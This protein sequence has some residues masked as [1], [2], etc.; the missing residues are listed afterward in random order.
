[1]TAPPAFL[2]APS[3]LQDDRPVG[4]TPDG[5]ASPQ[6]VAAQRQ[7]RV[8]QIIG[9]ALLG[10]TISG[11]A[12]LASGHWA[13]AGVLTA[14]SLLMVLAGLL[15]RAKSIGPG[16]AVLLGSLTVMVS[17]FSWMNHGLRDHS[18]LV[19]PAILIFAGVFGSW[20]LLFGLLA[21]M[22]T[23]VSALALADIQGWHR[24][25]VPAFS[26][27]SPVNILVILGVTAASVWMMTADLRRALALLR[28]ENAR[29]ERS[30]EQLEHM[31]RHDAL[32][33]LP[34]RLVA[35]DRFESARRRANRSSQNVALL[36]LDLDQFKT[37]NDSLGHVAGDELLVQAGQRLT[38]LVRRADTVCRLGG[39]EFL[40][41]LPDLGD[42]QAAAALATKV[43]QVLAEP[44]TVCG[45]EVSTTASI[46]V[47]LHPQDGH[48]FDEVLKNVDIAMYKAKE[49]GGNAVRF[50]N[51]E[52]NAGVLEHT[53]LLAGMRAGLARGEFQLHFQ[54][55]HAL[56]SGRVIG[57]E[58]LLRWTHPERGPISPVRFIPVAEKSGFIVELGA[59]VVREACRQV[60]RWEPQLPAGFRVS[61]NLSPVQFRRG[62]V[63]AMVMQALESSGVSPRRLDLELTES[64][65]LE[66]TYELSSML[67]R[68]RSQGVCFSIDDFGTGYSNLGYLKRFEV[69]R[70]KIDQS[71]VRRLT[72]DA[73]DAAIVGAIVQMARSLRLATLAEGVEDEATLV[74]LRRLGCEEG[75]G[76]LW[77]KALP[78]EEFAAYLQRHC[79]RDADLEVT[80]EVTG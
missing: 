80:S 31:A 41:V 74:A 24:P 40:L 21:F 9:A 46:G 49:A 30:R 22:M 51:P 23:S 58:A 52:M 77:A 8:M 28:R 6:E 57:A 39:D 15:V 43:Q 45:L 54:P 53:A 29:V 20:R 72:Q 16:V 17:I 48:Q 47:A 10:T 13:N 4:S 18:L 12:N 25:A 44:F 68:L 79:E 36:Y 65:L 38:R 61:V 37:I 5:L 19:Y 2:D 34:N 26:A 33:G 75:Q 66:E 27:S 42:A 70:L 14:V 56:D 32:T 67:S 11:A 59:W 1:V 69:T 76:W 35:R 78:P 3:T 62:D 55:Q 64:V 73:H 7:Q 71:F 63:E 60:A 50:F